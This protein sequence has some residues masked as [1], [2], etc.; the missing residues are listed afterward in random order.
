MP[1]YRVGASRYA[2]HR[3]HG[4]DRSQMSGGAVNTANTG[5]SIQ[6]RFVGKARAA[7]RAPNWKT[8]AFG[9]LTYAPD[10]VL[11]AHGTVVS[12]MVIG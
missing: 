7:S 5:Y 9:E 11:V 12:S 4:G 1:T 3:F 6:Q 10:P 2:V 8:D